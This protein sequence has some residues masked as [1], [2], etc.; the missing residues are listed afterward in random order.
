MRL[1]RLFL[2]LLLCLIAPILMWGQAP[3]AAFTANVTTGCSPLSVAFTDQSTGSPKSW[4]WDFGN[5]QLSNIQNPSISFSPGTY[6]VTLVVRNENGINSITKTNYIVSNPSPSAGFDADKY[7]VCLPGTVQFKDFSTPNA[8]TINAWAWDFGDGQKSTLQNPSH[9]Y[10]TTGFYDINLTV[11]SSTGC[12]GSAARTRFIRVVNGVKADFSVSGPTTCSPP[13]SVKYNNLTSGPGALTYNWDLGNSTTS[14][15]TS[16]STTYVSGGNYTVKLTASSEYGCAD[17]IKKVIPITGSATS[18]Q[19]VGNKDTVCLGSPISFQS[20]ATP[21]PNKIVWDFGDGSPTY[22]GLTP[23]A[24]TYAAAGVYNVTITAT[25][26]NCTSTATKKITVSGKPVVDFNAPNSGGCKAPVNVNFQNTSPDYIS[27]NWDFGDGGTST[28]IAP[29]VPHSYTANSGQYSV[30][31]TIKDSKGCSNTITKSNFVNIFTPTVALQNIPVGVCKNQSFSPG[32]RE[33]TADGIQS[34][35]WDFGDGSAIDPSRYPT[36]SYTTNN[37]YTIKLVITTRT[38]CTATDSKSIVVGPPPTV[39]FAKISATDCRSKPVQFV[40]LTTPSNDP[41]ITY[42]WDF[43]DGYTSTLFAPSHKYNDTGFLPVKLV[44]SL[45]GCADSLTKAG[46]V[47]IQ[48][49][50]ANFGYRIQNCLNKYTVVFSDSSF[51]DIGYPPVSYL[52][53]FG[54]PANTTSTA[55]NPSFTFPVVPSTNYNTQLIVN[56]GVCFDTITN[57]VSVINEVADF[58]IVPSPVC[59]KSR[60]NFISSNNPAFIK[61]YEW[62]IDG[63][64][65]ELYKSNYD[66]SFTTSGTHNVS[67]IATDINGCSSTSAT[68]PVQVTGPTALFGVVNKGGCKNSPVQFTDASTPAPG[69]IVK[70]SWN[71]G[72][73]S[74]VSNTQ[75]PQHAYAD[76]GTYKVSL[77]VTDDTNC[78]DIYTLDSAVVITRPAVSFSA[79][80]TVF[81]P[82]VPL[83]FTDSSLGKTLSYTW[84]FGDGAMASVQNPT[85]IFTGKDSAYTIKLAVKDSVGCI[86]SLVKTNYISVRSPKPFYS[87][88]DTVTYCPPLETKFT[89]KGLDAELFSWDFGDGG[90]SSLP[91]PNHFYNTYGTYTAKLFVTGYGGCV[92]SASINISVID[93]IAATKVTF[94][95]SPAQACNNL[96]VNFTVSPPNGNKFTFY[97]GDGTLDT[98]GKTSIS[99]YY[100]LPNSYA[101]YIFVKDSTGCELYFG[102]FG[103]VNILGAVPLFGVDKKKFCDSGA[104]YLTDYSQ[105]GRDPIISRTW[106][107]GDGSPTVVLPKDAQHKYTQ[108]GLYIPKLSVTTTANCTSVFTDTVRVL[109]TPKPFIA[110][111]AGVCNDSAI[112]LAGSLLNPPDTAIIWKWDLGSGQTSSLQNLS[113]PYDDTG[114][115]HI[116]LTATNSLGCKG[117]TSKNIVVYPLP[118]IAITGDTSIVS[119]GV[120]ITMPVTYSP[121]TVSYNWTPP[122]TLSCSD[123]PNPFANPKFTTTYTVKVTD[124]NSCKTSR[125][126]T[127]VVTCNNKNF[128]IPN[129]FS[130]NNDGANDRFYPRGTG[131]NLI[132]AMRIF[133]RW[134]ELMFEKRNFPANDASSGWDGM[135]KGKPAPVDTYIYMIDI[136]CENAN[137]IT[138]KANVTL[139]R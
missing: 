134:G 85:H 100:G 113:V 79:A 62:V 98:S 58:T 136:I 33:V 104:V 10:T 112:N 49:P 94:N 95:P 107:F 138:Y 20:T 60:V 39:D 16:P 15:Q 105:D 120:G 23:P 61:T 50:V 27:A 11:T 76:T 89:Y 99:H 86:D 129:T 8:G 130:P 22:T 31:L 13:F 35:A 26:S 46:L 51:T 114:T 121:N 65:P 36:H 17:S 106:D 7:I 12:K 56:N 54:D 55:Q 101:P 28:S 80:Q 44:A 66:G 109:A 75:N 43:G 14:T 37:T 5:G 24:K 40:N 135:Y 3:V 126:I 108:P 6:T 42:L 96:T 137:V 68:K 103:T 91:T 90:S 77:T 93:P 81:C 133:N 32:F 70:W 63:A 102:G 111:N 92:D 34:Y 123:C 30:S 57:I 29:A 64:A 47:H 87:V 82:G 72:D 4:N 45:N 25:F 139:I 117:D 67:L 110:S 88:K 1:L 41:T 78:E 122:A 74:P 119:G 125:N 127:L 128:F 97:Y 118:S 53:H 18:F 69:K 115:H 21:A 124:A 19:T 48:P 73:G 83:Q 38:G 84:D 2:S 9:T 132:Q 116:A 59:K 71:F 52:W 131:L